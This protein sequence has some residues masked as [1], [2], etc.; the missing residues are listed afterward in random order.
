MATVSTISAPSDNLAELVDKLGGIPLDR[1]RSQ[2]PPG[3]AKEKDVIAAL[4]APRKRIC[5]LVEGVLVEKAMGIRESFLGVAIVQILGAFVE[6]YDLGIVLGADGALRFGPMLVR[7]PDVCF[8]SWE[9]L[10]G[11]EV[12][13][14]PIP[15]LAPDLAIEVLSK[16]NTKREM[17]RKL[18]DYFEAGAQVVWLIQPKDQLADIYT[19][20]TKCRQINK[21]EVL[22]AGQ[23]LPGF[24]LPL[25]KLF[26]RTKRRRSGR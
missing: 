19:F 17:E 6:K 11:E 5:E 20:T 26:E 13:N 25:K 24:R 15:N 18:R 21:N 14:D 1:I 22:D 8:I 7:I 4:E 12:P 3:T 16:G 10:P 2:P 23:L 9:N